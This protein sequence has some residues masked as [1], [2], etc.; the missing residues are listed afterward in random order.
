[1]SCTTYNNR[2]EV[3]KGN[4]KQ[5]FCTVYD[6]SDNLMD[7]S[8]YTAGFYAKKYPVTPSSTVDVS[9]AHT[10]I[11]ASGFII[12]NL[13]STDTSIAKGD[14]TYEIIIEKTGTK[15]T[16]VQDTMNVIESIK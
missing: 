3:F 5:L 8:S 4:T 10:T 1:M 2:L 14:Y 11:D 15:I 16:V 6:S 12:F 7:L 9:V 13:S